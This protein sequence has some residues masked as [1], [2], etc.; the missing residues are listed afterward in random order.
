MTP[1][2]LD[3]LAQYVRDRADEL[4]LNQWRFRV[5]DEPCED[6]KLA[7]VE[8]TDGKFHADIRVIATF[9]DFKPEDQVDA[10]LHELLHC[11]ISQIEDVVRLDLFETRALSQP[12]YEMVTVSMRRHVE[13]VVDTLAHSLTKKF[14]PI[15]WAKD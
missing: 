5:S 6:G 3:M 12:M 15:G 11:H 10:V 4:G 8:W 13:Y 2:D 7:E 14:P 9:R 1:Q